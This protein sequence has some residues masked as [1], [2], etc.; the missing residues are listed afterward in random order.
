MTLSTWLRRFYLALTALFALISLNGYTAVGDLHAL[1]ENK[2]IAHTSRHYHAPDP[3]TSGWQLVFQDEFEQSALDLRK[4]NAEVDCW[5]GGN[6]EL[7]CY[8]DRPEN[9][10]IKEGILHMVA[11]EERFSGPKFAEI[12]PE[13]NRDDKSKTNPFTSARLQTKQKMSIRYGR[14]DVRAKVSA[15]QGMWSAI[16]MLPT[17][18]VYGSWPT[19]GEIDI[20]ESLNPGITANEV[21]GTLHYGLPWP[22]WENKVQAFHMDTSPADNFHVYSIEWEKDEIRWYVDGIH[23]QTQSAAGWYNYIW[24]GQ[25]QGFQVANPEA[26]FDQEFYLIMNVAVG[27]NWPGEPDRNWP[28]DRKM[29]VDYVRVYQCQNPQTKTVQLDGKGCAT[30]N[31]AVSLN[32]DLGR[33]ATR[34]F[35]L[36]ADGVETL[37][38]DVKGGKITHT[39]KA[40]LANPDDSLVTQQKIMLLGKHGKVW[41]IQFTG[42][43]QASLASHVKSSIEGY[44]KGLIFEGGRSWSNNGEIEFDLRVRNAS[45]DSQLTLGMISDQGGKGQALIKLPK[46]GEWQ[47]VV[48]K[49]ADILASKSKEQGG[50]DLANVLSPFVLNY[51]GTNAYIQID[52]IKVECAYNSEPETW[53][54]DQSCG[55]SPRKTPAK[56]I[57]GKINQ[58]DWIAWDCCSGAE[59]SSVKDEVLANKVLE[60]TFT[61]APTASGYISPRPLDMTPYAGGTLEFDFK[62]INP[63]PEG[64][65]WYVKLEADITAAQVLLSDGGPRPTNKWQHYTFEL[66][67]GLSEADL[68]NIKRLLVFPDWGKAEGAVMRIN[69]V[70]FVPAKKS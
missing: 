27:G 70:R 22:Q 21:H 40:I 54:L 33:P 2:T 41:D 45:S 4:W 1:S 34:Q 48:V 50:V 42:N 20:M 61:Q 36:F 25:E 62:Q 66:S 14:V 16:W 60:F 5:G 63:P 18:N 19:S 39:L 49:V 29:L 59:F 3:T 56:T 31:P 43:G 58:Q 65:Q 55:L 12:H 10:F 69:N 51:S 57:Y 11:K 38:F 7:Q 32:S 8:T 35:T 23:Y 13:Y 37:D 68:Q 9:A 47:H 17:D 28:D 26:P 64:S 44:E 15:G 53:Q 30:V 52:N 24:R 67:G 6:H 46:T